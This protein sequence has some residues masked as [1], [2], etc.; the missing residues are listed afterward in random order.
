[1]VNYCVFSEYINSS[2]TGRGGYVFSGV[3]I[4]LGSA[5]M[6]C[7]KMHKNN[8]RRKKL[9]RRNCRERNEA[10]GRSRRIIADSPS[11]IL[12][13]D[14]TIMGIGGVPIAVPTSP[15]SNSN[16]NNS[17]VILADAG[18]SRSGGGGIGGL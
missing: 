16:M 10:N 18:G 17:G 4:I 12:A 3:C 6:L 7:I 15:D 13:P 1:M 5:I 14:G 8:I 11:L 2:S 9:S